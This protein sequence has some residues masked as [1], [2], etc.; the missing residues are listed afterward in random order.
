M[1]SVFSH[2]NQVITLVE[3]E[4]DR[5]VRLYGDRMQC[6][7]GCSSC[8]SQMFRITIMDAIMISRKMK[9]LPA[10]ERDDLQARAQHYIEER[11]RL[12]HQRAD[13]DNQNEREVPTT[14]L[15]LPCP[16]LNEQG[17]C[18]IYDA[19]PVVCRKWGIPLF[20]PQ[21]PTELQACELNFPP[22]T[23]FE[24]EE[25][26]ELIDRQTEIAE[27]WQAVKASVNDRYQ[28]K[29][30]STTIAEAIAGDYEEMMKR[31]LARGAPCANL[32]KP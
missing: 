10:A 31:K 2:Y 8:C 19:R 21:H 32:P 16:A 12:I 25:L 4:F 3:A 5:N 11:A 1:N 27:R 17:A 28:P 26:D 24:D 9:Q 13:E 14:G 23:A 30:T 15:R 22:G 6:G 18:R 7:S 20:D 29:Q